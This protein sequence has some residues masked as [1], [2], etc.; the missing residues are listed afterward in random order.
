MDPLNLKSA[1]AL[2]FIKGWP[3]KT[4]F[5]ASNYVIKLSMPGKGVIFHGARIG[6]CHL[7]S[8][9][10]QSVFKPLFCGH[11]FEQHLLHAVAPLSLDYVLNVSWGGVTL[12]K[13]CIYIEFAYHLSKRFGVAC[14]L[15]INFKVKRTDFNH[16]DTNVLL[17]KYVLNIKMNCMNYV[18]FLNM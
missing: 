4:S 13:T 10:V 12:H 11:C 16:T 6:F 9:H 2:H 17:C 18:Y 14:P 15:L 8:L 3:C 7:G 5:R 1:T